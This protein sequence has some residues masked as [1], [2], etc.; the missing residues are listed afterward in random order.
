MVHFGGGA[1]KLLEQ[2]ARMRGLTQ[3]MLET[4]YP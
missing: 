1:R 3:F 2:S 4:G